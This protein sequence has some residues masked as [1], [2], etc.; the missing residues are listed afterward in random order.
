MTEYLRNQASSSIFHLAC[1]SPGSAPTRDLPDIEQCHAHTHTSKHGLT[2]EAPRP[3]GLEGMLREG[4][5]GQ[6]R[7]SLLWRPRWQRERGENEHLLVTD[8]NVNTHHHS[9]HQRLI[10]P[11]INCSRRETRTLKRAFAFFFT[12]PAQQAHMGTIRGIRKFGEG[13]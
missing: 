13:P 11:F 4:P 10:V 3:A 9:H 12:T 5:G 1:S 7:V 2:K 6:Q 8:S